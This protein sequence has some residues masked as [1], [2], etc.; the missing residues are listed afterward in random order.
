MSTSSLIELSKVYA[1]AHAPAWRRAS[2]SFLVVVFCVQWAHVAVQP[3]GDFHLH[4]EFGR[5]LAD[6]EFI[7]ERGLN[8]PPVESETTWR[9]S[10]W[11]RTTCR[12]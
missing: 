3:R 10:W 4:W 9:R 11:S 12:T 8:L 5:R 7:Y 6:G 1:A 2:L